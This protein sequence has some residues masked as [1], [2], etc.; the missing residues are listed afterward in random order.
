MGELLVPV[1]VAPLE[2]TRSP[3]TCE[4]PSLKFAPRGAPD[5]QVW[6]LLALGLRGREAEEPERRLKAPEEAPRALDF[7]AHLVYF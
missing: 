7:L 5:T 6:H 1:W 3:N 2:R 4:R